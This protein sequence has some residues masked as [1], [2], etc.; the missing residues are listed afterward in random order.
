MVG[1]MAP[2][3]TLKLIKDGETTA[4]AVTPQAMP[5]PSGYETF[6]YTVD[7]VPK[8]EIDAAA[9]ASDVHLRAFL[10]RMARPGGGDARVKILEARLPRLFGLLG[11]PPGQTE[12]ELRL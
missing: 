11:I 1:G 4:L 10:V 5:G 6:D 2:V 12:H 7:P 8:P 3:L 9:L